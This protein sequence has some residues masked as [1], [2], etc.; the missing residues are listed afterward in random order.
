MKYPKICDYIFGL[1]IKYNNLDIISFKNN[2]ITEYIE[3]LYTIYN[4]CNGINIFDE[5]SLNMYD[6]SVRLLAHVIFEKLPT[7]YE[8]DID[9]IPEYNDVI[10]WLDTLSLEDYILILYT[11]NK[12]KLMDVS[13][14]DKISYMLDVYLTIS[15]V[16]EE[17]LNAETDVVDTTTNDGVE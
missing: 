16:N 14:D 7:V 5:Q 13:T 2:E 15:P 8:I 17:V 12:L 9:T 3:K 11:L 1:I 4:S 10:N 6:Q